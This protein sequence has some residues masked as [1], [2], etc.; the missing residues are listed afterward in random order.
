M[1]LQRC[2]ENAA[3]LAG[4]STGPLCTFRVA[5]FLGRD[6]RA[7]VYGVLFKM[8]TT[9][10]D[11]DNVYQGGLAC[12]LDAATGR[13]AAG[14]DANDGVFASHPVSGAPIEGATI[15]RWRDVVALACAAQERLPVPWTVGW[16]LALTPDG[17]VLIEGNPRWNGPEMFQISE[18][19]SVGDTEFGRCLL[20]RVVRHEPSR[21]TGAAPATLRR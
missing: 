5:T 17:P 20:D 4:Y 12:C 7:A 14:L 19:V 18:N 21:E 11:V 9:S 10:V 2:L 15:P 13:L 8:P 3:E 16:D 1:L 6:G